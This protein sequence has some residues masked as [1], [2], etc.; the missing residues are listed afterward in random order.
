[1]PTEDGA[2]AAAELN[3]EALFQDAYRRLIATLL[4][5]DFRPAG[6]AWSEIGQNSLLYFLGPPH[7]DELCKLIIELVSASDSRFSTWKPEAARLLD[8][9]AIFIASS[10]DPRAFQ[11]RLRSLLKRGDAETVLRLFSKFVTRLQE[12][13]AH[14]NA[15]T[16]ETASQSEALLLGDTTHDVYA[17]TFP[18]SIA[19]CA[20]T[21]YAMK[22]SFHGA[23]QAL[24]PTNSII[25]NSYARAFFTSLQLPDPMVSQKAQV[26]ASRVIAALHLTRPGSF[27]RHVLN[28]TK[29]KSDQA[30][31]QLYEYLVGALKEPQ[32]WLTV[33]PSA[34]SQQTPILLPEFTWS[35]L[36]KGFLRCRRLDL[37]EKLWDD[38]T[39]FG[40]RPTMDV[41]TA[42]L[43]GYAE[44]RMIDR[45]LL[46][47]NLILKQR[48]RPS[49]MAHRALIYG[50]FKADRPE[51]AMERFQEFSASLKQGDYPAED[52]GVLIIYNTVMYWLL[53]LSRD[54]DALALLQDMEDVGPKPDV[55]TYNTFIRYYTNMSKPGAIGDIMRRMDAVG[56]AAD[57]VTYSTVLSALLPVAEDVPS[58][59][60]AMIKDYGHHLNAIAYSTIISHFMK[61]ETDAGLEAAVE[62]L[63]VMETQED[64]ALHPTTITYT[65]ILAGIH[66]R[67]K[68]LNPQVKEDYIKGIM[69]RMKRRGHMF[70]KS[71]YNTLIQA[72]LDDP[73][74]EGAT[75]ALKYYREMVR[76]NTPIE[77]RTWFLLLRGLAQRHA[78]DEADF[79]VEEIRKSGRGTTAWLRAYCGQ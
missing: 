1:M 74:P 12:Q 75:S 37:G 34:V 18:A 23:V 60:R 16:D 49:I 45:A 39:K 63:R 2:A 47:W 32:P 5:E 20:I 38:M 70:T 40:V 58:V 64:M 15:E 53:T 22:D 61:E 7:Y 68:W 30:L 36:L 62:L 28:M 6:K 31:Q 67:R 44:L 25:T 79:L 21:A 57:G 46:A 54:A 29:T 48:Q 8:D 35:I 51:E 26:F 66:R 52:P 3:S 27:Q 19:C 43:E 42:L 65:I 33:D 56:V 78:W 17:D 41:W 11:A 13:T 9:I 59:V 14:L 24:L 10:G 50:F 72:C 69:D 71:T 4:A 55:V 77:D 73:S 76:T